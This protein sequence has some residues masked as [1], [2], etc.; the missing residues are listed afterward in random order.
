MHTPKRAFAF[1]AACTLPLL[2]LTSA[3]GDK[4]RGSDDS[5]GQGLDADGDGVLTP[6]DCDDSDPDT[7][8]GASEIC[9]EQDNNCDGVVDEGVDLALYVDADGDGFGAPGVVDR[10]CEPQAGLTASGGDCDDADSDTHPDAEDRCD[11]ADNNCDGLVDEAGDTPWYR[12][13]D[14]DGYGSEEAVQACDPPSGYVALPGDCDD[15]TDQVNPGAAEVCDDDLDNDCDGGATG[16]RYSGERRDAP[17][18]LFMETF[19]SSDV[20]FGRGL[21]RIGRE[22]QGDRLAISAPLSS[23]YTYYGGEAFV[24][25]GEVKDGEGATGVATLGLYTGGK[26]SQLGT[27]LGS[28][29]DVDGDGVEELLV[30]LYYGTDRAQ[31]PVVVLVSGAMT[32]ERSITDGSLFLH[33]VDDPLGQSPNFGSVV[34]GQGDHDADGV[35]DLIIG[36]GNY[37]NSAGLSTGKVWVT[38]ANHTGA[39]AI[40]DV[41]IATFDGTSNEPVGVSALWLGDTNGDGF[42]DALIGSPFYASAGGTRQGRAL[43]YEGPLGGYYTAD[44]AAVSVFGD[45]DEDYLGYR[46]G[47]VGDYNGDGYDDLLVAAPGD[48]TAVSGGGTVGL[49]LSPISSSKLSSADLLIYGATKDANAFSFA[50]E[51]GD[52]DGD[53]YTDLLIGDPA[54]SSGGTANGAL[55]LLYGP[56]TGRIHGDDLDAYFIGDDDR[57]AVGVYAT[58]VDLDGDGV[59]EIAFGDRDGGFEAVAIFPG[60]GL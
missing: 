48:S 14:G 59:D 19:G 4:D 43:V 28:A 54:A 16:C 21:V 46:A 55:G 24:V 44:D 31:A 58:F 6:V 53:G 60:L 27:T 37:V 34:D 29:Q 38:P 49:W 3:C 40:Y 32:G 42:D 50:I 5:G 25:E 36:D 26:S 18:H 51:S 12:D 15:G 20:Y 13:G 52:S 2:L 17:V 11:G 39:L 56:T 33:A 9:D 41:A 7:K 30:G 1:A 45:S 23:R 47:R 35:A 10:A 22:G 57:E 8:P